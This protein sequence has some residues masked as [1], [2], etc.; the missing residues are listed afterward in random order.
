MQS[1]NNFMN[2]WMLNQHIQHQSAPWSHDH[3]ASVIQPGEMRSEAC[4]WRGVCPCAGVGCGCTGTMPFFRWTLCCLALSI[5]RSIPVLSCF[6][7]FHWI[8]VRGNWCGVNLWDPFGNRCF[9][10]VWFLKHSETVQDSSILHH[11]HHLLPFLPKISWPRPLSISFNAR[12][13][14][15]PPFL[16]TYQLDLALHPMRLGGLQLGGKANRIAEEA[17]RI[18]Q[19]R[20]HHWFGC[21]YLPWAPW[22]KNV[23]SGMMGWWDDGMMGWWDDGMMGMVWNNGKEMGDE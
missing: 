10:H 12:F 16:F 19:G 22:W 5:K 21:E 3:A 7:P 15:M 1:L 18:R 2:I 17:N 20:K 8:W 23:E 9:H 14:C 6:I 11:L 4:R 13:F